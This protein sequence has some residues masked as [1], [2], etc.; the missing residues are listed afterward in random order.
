MPLSSYAVS[1]ALSLDDLLAWER[2]LSVQGWLVPLRCRP[3]LFVAVE[4][5][6]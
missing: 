5:T 6:T 3:A 1:Q 4:V 2:W